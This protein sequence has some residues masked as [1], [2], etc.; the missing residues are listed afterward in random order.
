[1]ICPH[2][3]EFYDEDNDTQP[4]CV[5]G[6]PFDCGCE[7]EYE[8]DE[9]Q[10]EEWDRQYE[11]HMFEQNRLYIQSIASTLIENIGN[12]IFFEFENT[13]HNIKI[14]KVLTADWYCSIIADNSDHE[15]A[16]F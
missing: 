13:I 1:M 5:C 4:C 8:P 3:N 12:D 2:C 15:S 6:H 10:T 16:I 11:E 7:I 9:K 14:R